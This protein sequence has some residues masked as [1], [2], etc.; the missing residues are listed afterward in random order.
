MKTHKLHSPEVNLQEANGWFN[1]LNLSMPTSS[2]E[3]FLVFKAVLHS[4]RDTLNAQNAT[5]LGTHLPLLIKG[6]Y[7]E[8]WDPSNNPRN[9]SCTEDFFD[10]VDERYHGERIIEAVE[11]ISAVVRF[12]SK[13]IGQDESWLRDFVPKE[14]S[15][16]W[17]VHNDE[18]FFA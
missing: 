2:R 3:T 12:L 5:Y 15:V 10:I 9:L 14:L 13:K 7:Y 8:G 1:E 16:L 17:E 4:I 18:E 6:I 11:E